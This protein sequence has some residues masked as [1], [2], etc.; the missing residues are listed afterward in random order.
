MRRPPWL[1]GLLLLVLAG[2][3]VAPLV[4]VLGTARWPYLVGLAALL[5]IAFGALERFWQQRSLP[6]PR[7]VGLRRRFRILSGGKKGNGHT[8]DDSDDSGDKPRWVM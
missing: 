2:A 6:R 3:F 4:A 7:R 8:E 5:L 1:A